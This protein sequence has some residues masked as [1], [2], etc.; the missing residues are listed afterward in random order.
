MCDELDIEDVYE[1]RIEGEE[2]EMIQF[3]DARKLIL[4][5][6]NICCEGKE[7]IREFAAQFKTGDSLGQT[8][9]EWIEANY[10]TIR[11][12]FG[13]YGRL[14]NAKKTALISRKTDNPIKLN[15]VA[16][17]CSSKAASDMRGEEE[18]NVFESKKA[19]TGLLARIMKQYLGLS[20][21]SK[22]NRKQ[23]N[24]N[25]YRETKYNVE[26]MDEIFEL[27]MY[28]DA[29]YGK[30]D[31]FTEFIRSWAEGNEEPCKWY[32]LYD[33]SVTGRT[34]QEAAKGLYELEMVDDEL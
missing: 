17:K 31:K 1:D 10:K 8:D 18:P 4:K 22:I 20:I 34:I 11:V 25:K 32:H 26:E 19:V 16:K 30:S 6:L 9:C 24:G 27:L 29:R 14:Q 23:E 7:D 13:E 3:M 12:V 21:T 15:T 2:K 28:M 5:L 33:P